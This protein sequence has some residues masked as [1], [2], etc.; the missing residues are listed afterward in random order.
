[1]PGE[2]TARRRP[3]AS[4]GQRPHHKST[5]PTPWSMAFQTPELGEIKFCRWIH[6]VC[7]TLL[8][9]SLQITSMFIPVWC[10]SH[11]KCLLAMCGVCQ[12]GPRW[13]VMGS[14]LNVWPAEHLDMHLCTTVHGSDTRQENKT[15]VT[16]IWNVNGH[17]FS[18]SNRIVYWKE[19]PIHRWRF[20]WWRNQW[21]PL[22]PWCRQ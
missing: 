9:Q 7:G 17:P 11:S 18:P 3:S 2:G 1:M 21:H 6:A 14:V 5:L 13:E 4:Q 19:I 20:K 12:A 10:L 8:G 16:I 22:L 15:G